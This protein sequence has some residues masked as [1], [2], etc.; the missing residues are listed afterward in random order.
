MSYD[1]YTASLFKIEPHLSIHGYFRILKF[2]PELECI[3]AM[4]DS[5]VKCTTIDVH[6]KI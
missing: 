5:G 1:V 3:Y 2:Y 4:I 6:T